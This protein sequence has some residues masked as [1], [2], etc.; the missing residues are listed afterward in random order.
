MK[1]SYRKDAKARRK[2]S[3][4]KP[5]DLLIL[6]KIRGRLISFPLRLSAVASLR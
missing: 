2:E 1:K 3:T 4:K 5:G 6:H